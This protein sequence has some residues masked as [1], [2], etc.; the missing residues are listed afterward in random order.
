MKIDSRSVAADLIA[1]LGASGPQSPEVDALAA[2]RNSCSKMDAA[3][4]MACL[5]AAF[6]WI[7]AIAERL[8]PEERSA[9]WDGITTDAS[10]AGA[11][12]VSAFA[13]D[14]LERVDS[15]DLADL[16]RFAAVCADFGVVRAEAMPHVGALIGAVEKAFARVS[17]G[18]PL[19]LSLARVGAL[20]GGAAARRLAPCRRSHP[21]PADP[22]D[23]SDA[24]ARG[25][26]RGR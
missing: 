9:V 21:R 4:L 13:V 20:A 11:A 12:S 16:T 26:A 7:A 3:G 1:R 23:A 17:P 14:L 10:I 8:S 19:G 18:S 24:G 25:A 15:P 6:D 2:A 5:R 22:S